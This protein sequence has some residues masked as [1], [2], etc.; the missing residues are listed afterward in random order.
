MLRRKRG[1]WRQ[2]WASG[3][4]EECVQNVVGGGSEL[5]GIKGHCPQDRCVSPDAAGKA[6]EGLGTCGLGTAEVD[7]PVRR[8]SR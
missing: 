2:L 1:I 7:V 3:G 8:R 6:A 5:L 4:E